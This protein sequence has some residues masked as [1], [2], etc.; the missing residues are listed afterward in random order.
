MNTKKIQEQLQS[1]EEI[2]NNT[3]SVKG[4]DFA[5]MVKFTGTMQSYTRMVIA[6]L[7]EANASEEQIASMV[8]RSALFASALCKAHLDALNVSVDQLDE[9]FKIVDNVETK[10]R[11]AFT[12]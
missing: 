6:E 5:E 4:K 9:I 1:I 2:F 12:T 11:K 8:E 10:V 7:V 3:L